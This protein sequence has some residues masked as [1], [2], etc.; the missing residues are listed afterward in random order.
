MFVTK[1]LYVAILTILVTGALSSPVLLTR[2][3]KINQAGINLIKEFEGFRANFYNDPGV[4]L[5][6][7]LFYTNSLLY[8]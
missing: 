3:M 5:C 1:I 2:A 6:L 8:D 7:F 4:S